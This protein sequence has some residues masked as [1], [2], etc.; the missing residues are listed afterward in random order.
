MEERFRHALDLFASRVRRNPRV[1]GIIATGSV[2]SSKPDKNSDLDVFIL[3]DKSQTRERGN[4]WVNGVEVEY[5]SNPVRQVRYELKQERTSNSAATAYMFANSIVIFKRSSTVDELVKEAKS[6]LN[7]KPKAMGAVQRENGKYY[8]D[9]GKKD[10]E[11]MYLKN[12]LFAFYRTANGLL[13]LCL[14]FFYAC[15]RARGTKSKQLETHLKGID[16]RFAHLF[17]KATTLSTM[18]EKYRAVKNV[19]EYVE[20]LLGGA[21][22]REWKL[23]GPLSVKQ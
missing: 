1:I 10:L 3:L 12:D 4:T 21:R 20:K 19:A 11:D 23:R 16:P 14:N 13:D 2:V 7:T 22:S 8:I 18:A 15:K 5:F 9:D 17:I 6:I